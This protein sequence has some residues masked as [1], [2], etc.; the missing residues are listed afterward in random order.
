M[1]LYRDKEGNHMKGSYVRGRT[2]EEHIKEQMKDPAFKK[3]WHGLDPEFE[4]L[5]SML[6]IRGK[7]GISQTELARRM[8][9]KQPALSRLERGGI[10]KASVE[11]L[12]KIADALNARL[13][14][15]LEPKKAKAA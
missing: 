5:E 6:K 4:L 7:A 2:L 11:T 10:G 13:I 14:V 8:G 9:V 12:K 15:K 3:A 1:I